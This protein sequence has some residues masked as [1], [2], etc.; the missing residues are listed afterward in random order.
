MTALLQAKIQHGFAAIADQVPIGGGP[1][2]RL[3]DIAIF[4]AYT[5]C[6]RAMAVVTAVIIPGIFLFRVLRRNPAIQT[7]VQTP[8]P[9]GG[10]P[11]RRRGSSKKTSLPA[12]SAPLAEQPGRL[13]H[14]LHG[15]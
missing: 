5:G 6:F 3:Q 4:G 13:F 14:D 8:G 9:P 7:V 1:S 15:C 11:A 2:S 12:V 10:C